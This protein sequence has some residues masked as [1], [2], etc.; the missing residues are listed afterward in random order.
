MYKLIQSMLIETV[1]ANNRTVYCV[2]DYAPNKPSIRV[3]K[4]NP[5]RGMLA[6]VNESGYTDISPS[7]PL[8]LVSEIADLIKW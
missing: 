3:W 5:F 4:T 7:A 8:N 6:S 1:D 2:V